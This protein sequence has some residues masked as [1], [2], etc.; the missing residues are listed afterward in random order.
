[1]G[2]ITTT[3]GDVIR[4]LLANQLPFVLRGQ[5]YASTALVGAGTFVGLAA[6]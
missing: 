3:G 2:M 4:D 1:M 5:L 6:V